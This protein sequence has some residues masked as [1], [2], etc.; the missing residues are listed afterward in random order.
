MGLSFYF[1][2]PKYSGVGTCV[3]NSA[4][5]LKQ[6]DPRSLLDSLSN[7]IHDSRPSNRLHLSKNVEPGWGRWVVLTSNI[8]RHDCVY[9]CAS[10]H[11]Y[12]CTEENSYFLNLCCGRTSNG[13]VNSH[14]AKLSP[15]GLLKSSPWCKK[16]RAVVVFACYWH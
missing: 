11:T 14:W 1:Q 12:A 13:F 6:T 10:M 15:K 8:Y 7:Q 2:S 9:M 16:N 5:D 4:W 3:C